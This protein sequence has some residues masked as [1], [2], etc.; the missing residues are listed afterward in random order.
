MPSSTSPEP[1]P[2]SSPPWSL[3]AIVNSSP[4]PRWHRSWLCRP[5]R[6]HPQAYDAIHEPATMLSSSLW[7]PRAV[8]AMT[9]R[10][11]DVVKPTSCLS[12]QHHRPPQARKATLYIFLCHFGPTNPD[13]DILHC[14]CS[15]ALLWCA[16]LPHFLDMLHCLYNMSH[17]F[18]MLH[19]L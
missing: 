15:A 10:A 9:P 3:R 6:R 14:L 18:D 5:C 13:F 12:P 16:T 7:C 8:I 4:E 11:C 2:S 17:C 1:V 19:C